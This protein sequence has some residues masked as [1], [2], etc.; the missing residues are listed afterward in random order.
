MTDILDL[1]YFFIGGVKRR[2]IR[3]LTSKITYLEVAVLSKHTQLSAISIYGVSNLKLH[4]FGT[5]F[6]ET[7]QMLLDYT[8]VCLPTKNKIH[9]H[10]A[11]NFITL[12]F[13]SLQYPSSRHL[14]FKPIH[15]RSSVSIPL[16]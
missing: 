8:R 14:L 6:R 9:S 5:R 7:V 13:L 16:G 15:G 10:V 1:L 12:T 11:V 3:A 2:G 4:K